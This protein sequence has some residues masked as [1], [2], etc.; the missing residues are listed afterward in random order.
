MIFCIEGTS[1]RFNGDVRIRS[2]FNAA[3]FGLI[4]ARR[5]ERAR[6]TASRLSGAAPIARAIMDGMD[7][8]GVTIMKTEAGLDTGDMLLQESVAIEKTDTAGTLAT[9]LASVGAELIVK[10]L[11]II[12]SGTYRLKRQDEGFVCKKSPARKSILPVSQTR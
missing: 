5:L 4:S 11:R 9:R 3:H 12:E 2:D 7:R 8:T 1:R 10:A 6:V